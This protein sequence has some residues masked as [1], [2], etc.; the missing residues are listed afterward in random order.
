MR[1]NAFNHENQRKINTSHNQLADY[2]ADLNSC[3]TI[4]PFADDNR[5]NAS[6]T[7]KHTLL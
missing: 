2:G 3:E 7:Y 5:E 6:E 4:E 1:L